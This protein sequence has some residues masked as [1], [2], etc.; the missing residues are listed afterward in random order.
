MSKKLTA[1]AWLAL[2]ITKIQQRLQRLRVEDTGDLIRSIHGNIQE[3]SGGDSIKAELLYNYYGIFPDMGV[4][5]GIQRGDATVAKLVGSGRRRKPWTREIAAQRHRFIELMQIE[6]A[7]E[8]TQNVA[9]SLLK[10]IV[11]NL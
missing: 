7:D 11:I 5:K 10:K 6:F 8:V 9:D 2:A 4:G 3:L 1:E